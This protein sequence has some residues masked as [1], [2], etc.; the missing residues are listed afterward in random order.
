MGER[1]LHLREGGAP[2]LVALGTA[3]ARALGATGAVTVTPTE[4]EGMWTVTPGTKVGAIVVRVSGQ[5]LIQV[6]IAPKLEINRLVFLMGY[7]RGNDH[8]RDQPVVLDPAEDLPEALADALAS[9]GS[10]ALEQGVLKG[11]VTVDE[12]LPVLRGRI[13][14]GDQMR[15]SGLGLPLEVR[16]DDYSVDVTENQI[17]LAAILRTLRMPSI[18]TCPSVRA[19]LQ[20]LRLLLAD[21]TLPAVG[22]WA[23]RGRPTWEPSRLNARYVPALR[24]AEM[25]LDGSSFELRSGGLVVSGFLIDMAY[26]FEDF[27]CIAMGRAIGEVVSENSERKISP[28][29]ASLQYRTHLD[30]ERTVPIRPDLVWTRNARPDIVADAKYKAEKPSGFPQADL[31][32]MLAYCTVLGLD[33]GHLVYAKGEESAGIVWIE[34]SD[35]RIVRHVLDL[36]AAPGELLA[37]IETVAHTMMGLAEE[38]EDSVLRSVNV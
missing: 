24:V 20:R 4:S 22:N 34:G 28:G 1:T 29:R 9:L 37:Q 33:V 18:A 31:Y 35:I 15:H 3:T 5:E 2:A 27:V 32:Q 17:L 38:R 12:S 7:R 16:F 26:V 13:R 11:Y 23:R 21:V 10:R 14:V 30:R 36:E 6:R 19:R 8:W 25:I